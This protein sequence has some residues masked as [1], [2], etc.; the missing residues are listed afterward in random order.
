MTNEFPPSGDQQPAVP[1]SSER[2]VQ[3][4]PLAVVQRADIGPDFRGDYQE[5]FGPADLAR[6][7]EEFR[8]DWQD[9]HGYDIT[10]TE[11][12]DI[13]PADLAEYF[14]KAPFIT[15]GWSESAPGRHPA[16]PA[17]V[18]A[19][20]TEHW[21]QQGY[22]YVTINGVNFPVPSKKPTGVMGRAYFD[23]HGNWP[24]ADAV[25][26]A[27]DR[28]G[29]PYLLTI[30]RK[31]KGGVLALPGGQ[32]ESGED[33]KVA[34]LREMLEETMGEPEA[35]SGFKDVALED[36]AETIGMPP[37]A[38][39]SMPEEIVDDPRNTDTSC[40][41]TIPSMVVLV[42]GQHRLPVDETTG[43]PVLDQTG[44]SDAEA[45]KWIPI[46]DGFKSL[47]S[48]AQAE[49]AETLAGGPWYG[50][51]GDIIRR[52]LAGPM[53]EAFRN[54]LTTM[55]ESD[56]NRPRVELVLQKLSR[57]QSTE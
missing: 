6:V 24:A 50:S 12:G 28:D 33:P 53:Q 34:A 56:S 51:H 36:I 30:E 29:N 1:A 25:V 19:A 21:A 3:Q 16:N 48:N 23:R 18:D 15:C 11:W 47:S 49:L 10:E 44:Q 2:S 35:D 57:E 39:V 52:A 42:H 14:T 43:L 41:S 13:P 32:I 20:T 45:A 8:A 17:D 22:P 46:G 9:T 31:D 54:V 40:A 38:I 37:E 4:E 5:G 26:A 27:L 55:P 7:K